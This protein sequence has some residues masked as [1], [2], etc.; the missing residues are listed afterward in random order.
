MI[1]G[2]LMFASMSAAMSI[3]PDWMVGSWIPNNKD[4]LTKLII[5]RHKDGIRME[6]WRECAKGICYLGR[7][8]GVQSLKTKGSNLTI[9]LLHAKFSTPTETI[10]LATRERGKMPTLSVEISFLNTDTA[11]NKTATYTFRKEED[12]GEPPCVCIFNKNRMFNHDKI[13]WDNEEWECVVYKDDGLCEKVQKIN[14]SI[15][16]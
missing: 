11:A 10:S 2:F 1:V 14:Q 9:E 12:I 15:I 5:E 3:D 7:V 16:K 8:Q 4:V 13:V 6:A